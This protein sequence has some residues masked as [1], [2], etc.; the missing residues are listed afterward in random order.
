MKSA[1]GSGKGI[2]EV[3]IP[4]PSFSLAGGMVAW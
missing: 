2:E 3:N 1:E 4:E